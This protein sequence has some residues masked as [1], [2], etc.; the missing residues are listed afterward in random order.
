M[1]VYACMCV[2]LCISL[3]E[4]PLTCQSDVCMVSLKVDCWKMQRRFTGCFSLGCLIVMHLVLNSGDVGLLENQLLTWAGKSRL[5]TLIC[6]KKKKMKKK[7]SQ[8]ISSKFEQG[9]PNEQFGIL[10]HMLDVVD[11]LLILIRLE[12]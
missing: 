12:W 4:L 3:T 1:S 9:Y 7:W 2:C 5:L 10:N 8:W 11:C 6:S